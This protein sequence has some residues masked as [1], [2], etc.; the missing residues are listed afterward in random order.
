MRAE[1]V[2]TPPKMTIESVAALLMAGV[3]AD[4]AIDALKQTYTTESSLSSA[5]SRVRAAILDHDLRPPEYDPEPLRAL[6]ET[7][8]EIATFLTAPLRDQYRIQRL[9]R[10]RATWPPAAEQAL[11]YLQLLPANLAG[12]A[13]AREEMLSLKRRREESLLAKNDA[14]LVVPDFKALL[15]TVTAMLETAAPTDALP[16]LVLPLLL[17]SGRRFCELMNGKSTFAPEPDERYTLFSGQLKK[18][19]SQPPYRIPLLVPYSAF[20]KGLLALRQKQASSDVATLTNAKVT[21]RYQP[22]VQRGLAKGA[23]PGMPPCHIHDFRG[24]YVAAIN[25]L[26]VSPVSVP[27]TAM[28]VCGHEC[29]QDSLSYA[30]VRLDGATELAHSL[31]TLHLE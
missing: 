9:H 30:H 12:F 2:D 22:Q 31:G 25:L 24:T 13:L 6:A 5:M 16:R 21:A 29:L 8:P 11:A 7:T 26:F 10:S 18:R 28:K 1:W 17:V 27:R 15:A 20:A 14:L 4:Q 23:L 3:P 19:H